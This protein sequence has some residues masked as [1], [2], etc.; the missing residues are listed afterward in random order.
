MA[1][2]ESIREFARIKSDQ[3]GSF[4][5]DDQ[6]NTII[7]AVAR[8]VWTKM[9]AGGWN[10]G[11]A[12]FTVTA[13]PAGVT[14]HAVPIAQ[15]VLAVYRIDGTTHTPLARV[16]PE[17]DASYRSRGTGPAEVYDLS[18]GKN[19]ST[20]VS[21]IHLYPAPTSGDYKIIYL[22][23]FP[24]F[25]ND[26][27][28]WVGPAGSDELI[29]IGA[30]IQMLGKEGDIQMLSQ[31]RQDWADLYVEICDSANWLDAKHPPIVRDVRVPGRRSAFDFDASEAW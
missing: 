11:K 10:P 24:G 17:E 3:H 13:S 18:V 9:V 5:S 6:C 2:L 16:K 21:W 7:D 30:A 26:S 29:A 25:A 20:Y 23:G 31:L 4:P 12:E 22:P 27:E 19:F 1:T 14:S 28:A 8:R 15:S